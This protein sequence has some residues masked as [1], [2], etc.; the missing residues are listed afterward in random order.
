MQLYYFETPNARRPCAIARH[1]GLDVDFIHVDLRAGAHRSDAF[2]T[3]N[4]NGRVPALADGEH[5]LWEGRAI[6]FYLVRKAGSDLWPRDPLAQ[7]EVMKWMTWDAA[8]FS[9]HAT[10]LFFERAI[11]PA[12]GL[13]APDET[14]IEEATRFFHSFAAVLDDHLEGRDHLV[15]DGLTL[16]DFSV[17]AVLPNAREAQLPLGRYPQIRRWHEALMALE[18]WRQPWPEARQSFAA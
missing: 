1:L 18:A 14:A 5:R 9:R 13:G 12:F 11:K 3:I 8:H 6:M 16:A 2:R 7:A 10:T 4:P 15:G 17:A